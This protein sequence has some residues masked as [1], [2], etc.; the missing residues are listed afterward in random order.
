MVVMLLDLFQ[1]VFV[2]GVAWSAPEG[3]LSMSA[4][5]WPT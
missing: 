1:L 2:P 3:L 4:A 5:F